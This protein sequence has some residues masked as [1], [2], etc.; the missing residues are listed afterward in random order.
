M[1]LC[2]YEPD[3]SDEL[4]RGQSPE[5]E[6]TP[7]EAAASTGLGGGLGLSDSW[8]PSAVDAGS[9]APRLV[10]GYDESQ[11]WPEQT[12]VVQEAEPPRPVDWSL[13]NQRDCLHCLGG[14][15]CRKCIEGVYDAEPGRSLYSFNIHASRE[16][17]RFKAMRIREDLMI[18]AMV[19]FSKGLRVRCFTMTLSLEAQMSGVT[20]GM[21]GHE[22]GKFV[23]WLRY[24]CPDFAYYVVPQSHGGSRPSGYA[25]DHWHVISTGSDKLPVVAM[26]TWWRNHFAGS[27]I[28][29]MKEVRDTRGAAWYFSN[30]IGKGEKLCGRVM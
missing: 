20:R 15:V 5:L 25:N 18:M 9:E 22:W 3:G 29:G 27:T 10:L 19:A 12:S 26:A 1:R 14:R 30:Y 24:Y 16:K 13:A 8:P 28:S 17:S 6:R 23:R 4:P 7:E 2:E 11:P 21:F